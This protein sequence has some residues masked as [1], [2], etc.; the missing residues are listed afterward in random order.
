MPLNYSLESSI[1]LQ[2]NL[3]QWVTVYLTKIL[4]IQQKD[5]NDKIKST[6]GNCHWIINHLAN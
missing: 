5:I 6:L 4:Q 2:S 1:I 3:N